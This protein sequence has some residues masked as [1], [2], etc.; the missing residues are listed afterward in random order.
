MD[1]FFFL[2]NMFT[3]SANG[4]LQL[5]F[6]GRFTGKQIRVRHL[7]FY[8]AALYGVDFI[9]LRLR[10][11]GLAV[12]C[13]L[14]VLYGVNRLLLNNGRAASC[15]AAVLSLYVMQLSFGLTDSIESMIFVK[16]LGHTAL[17]NFMVV[18]ATVTALVMCFLVYRMILRQY[19]MSRRPEEPY[20]WM[21]LPPCVFFL[22]AEM[23]VLKTAYS[24]VAEPYKAEVSENLAMLTFQLLGLAALF[25]SLLACRHVRDGLQAQAELASLAQ[26]AD[27]QKTYVEQARARYE[28][29]RSFRHDVNEHLSVLAGLLSR[30]NTEQAETYLEKLKAVNSKLSFPYHSGNPVVD[31]ILEDK[32]SIAVADNTEVQ[33]SL[34]LP[35]CSVDD[36]DLCVIFSNALDNALKACAA[37]EGEKRISIR[38]KQQ[39]DFYFLEFENT[40]ESPSPIVAGT[41][42]SNIRT[43]TSRYGGAMT[44]EKTGCVFCLSVLLNISQHPDDRSLQTP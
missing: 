5:L 11:E 16:L 25:A 15:V 13:M 10:L 3:I 1:Y 36:L 37:I 29:T 42:L 27:A 24:G 8:L 20:V 43:I 14:I 12:F 17:I 38:G 35:P 7:L 28:L 19:S 30:G 18:A 26:A 22:A 6:C 32:L 33:L 9:F 34:N 4:V 2:L 40:C 39:G 44:A 31:I 23:Y 21:L 41:G